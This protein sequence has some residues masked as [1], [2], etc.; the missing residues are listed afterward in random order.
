MADAAEAGKPQSQAVLV[1]FRVLEGF[2]DDSLKGLQG[3]W[4]G[5]R[6]LHTVE[7]FGVFC[8]FA[9]WFAGIGLAVFDGMKVAWEGPVGLL[10][11]RQGIATKGLLP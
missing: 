2:Y 5:S 6:R 1:V 9:F 3:F 8:G 4:K 7:G 10:I 11:Y